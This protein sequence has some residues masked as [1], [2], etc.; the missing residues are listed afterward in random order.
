MLP[1]DLPDP[2]IKPRSLVLQAN[3]LLSEP[4]KKPREGAPNRE[5]K[6]SFLKEIMPEES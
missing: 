4:P 2:E 5:G 3:S 6:E 1:G